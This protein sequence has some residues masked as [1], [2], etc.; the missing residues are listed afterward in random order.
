MSD[1]SL[2]KV[3]GT[4]CLPPSIESDF[5]EVLRSNKPI[6]KN[7]LR[8]YWQQKN[9]LSMEGLPALQM[10]VPQDQMVGFNGQ[11]RQS[12]AGVKTKGRRVEASMLQVV[13]ILSAL[14]LGVAI[15]LKGRE[16]LQRV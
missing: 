10:L 2:A 12:G 5:S 13:A 6:Q 15:G 4:D 7:G 3:D 9:S 1:D 8:E 11:K 14:L 16:I